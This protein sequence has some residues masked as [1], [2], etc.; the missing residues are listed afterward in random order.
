M[1]PIFGLKRILWLHHGYLAGDDTDSHVDMLARL[2]NENTIAYVKCTDK[3]DEHFEELELMERELKTFRTADGEP[4]NL[5]PL[6]MGDVVLD[7]NHERL[8]V[9]YAN[10]LIMNGAVL[11]PFY[12]S[13]KDEEAKRQL[14][15]I[16]ID[17]EVIGVNCLALIKQHG[18]LHCS[19]MQYI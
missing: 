7:E 14:E 1:K 17:R 11:V 12:N 8:P 2:C 3:D 9:S 15:K 4:Y 18:S 19:T 10:F 13:S 16:F 5:V 6:P